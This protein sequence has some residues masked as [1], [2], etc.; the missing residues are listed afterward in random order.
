MIY[1]NYVLQTYSFDLEDIYNEVGNRPYYAFLLRDGTVDYRL[2][3]SLFENYVLADYYSLVDYLNLRYYN[4]YIADQT[5]DGNKE[6]EAILV[7][8][9]ATND[10]AV[11][12]T[13]NIDFNLYTSFE[14]SEYNV[15]YGKPYNNEPIFDGSPVVYDASGVTYNVAIQSSQAIPVAS[16]DFY[17]HVVL[18]YYNIVSPL[19]D[20]FYHAYVNQAFNIYHYTNNFIKMTYGDGFTMA[21]GSTYDSILQEGYNNGYG[22]GY[23]EGYN[24]GFTNGSRIQDGGVHDAFSY[25][26]EAFNGI[27]GIMALQVLPNV[28]LGLVFSIPLTIIL[29][30]TIFK[31]V[32]K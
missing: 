19:Q 8:N 3:D 31:L 21:L 1:S 23:L 7:V 26:S 32:R 20:E 11:I 24:D 5:L 30:M 9:N 29:I 15:F 2:N 17:G 13:S 22:A 16:N 28:S 4:T 6:L 14:G 12:N 18:D 25:I 27:G 10:V